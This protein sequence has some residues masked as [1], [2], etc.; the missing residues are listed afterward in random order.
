M[1]VFDEL[2]RF[3]LMDFLYFIA[4]LVT[5]IVFLSMVRFTEVG[6]FSTLAR[7]KHMGFLY[8]IAR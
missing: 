5:L 7:L 1:G 4:H 8:A 3:T 6:F 2:T